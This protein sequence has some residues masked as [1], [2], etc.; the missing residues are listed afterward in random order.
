MTTTDDPAR[1][2][3]PP[4]VL[5]ALLDQ[6]AEGILIVDADGTIVGSNAASASI[7]PE[8]VDATP[9]RYD[10]FADL[11]E[12]RDGA[13]R[14]LPLDAWPLSHALRGEHVA[15]FEMS[16][17]NRRTGETF[18]HE[19]DAGPVLGDDG[20]VLY[21]IS[22]RRDVT[23]TRQERDALERLFAS[24]HAAKLEAERANDL[25]VRINRLAVDLGRV[26]TP[27]AVANA[28]ARIARE[29]AEATGVGIV[30][31]EPDGRTLE[32][33]ATDGFPP[34]VVEPWRTFDVDAP[35]PLA[36]SVRTDEPVFVSSPT[37]RSAR[38]LG[39]AERTPNAISHAWACFPLHQTGLVSGAIGFGFPD[40]RTFPAADTA[41]L[42]A[43]ADQISTAIERATLL[44]DSERARREAEDA[45]R[46]LRR[47]EFVT[48]AAISDLPFEELLN[49]LLD[50]V[51]S[52]LEADSST[53]LLL[54]DE[55]GDLT[56]RAS[57]GLEGEI[58]GATRIPVGE[59]V[60][61]RILASAQPLVVEDLTSVAIVSRWV[62]ETMRSLVGVPLRVRRDLVG[63]LHVAT[64]SPRAFTNDDIRLLELVGARVASALE[65]AALY[66]ER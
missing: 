48:D 43:I 31:L 28:G 65:R 44:E 34:E 8:G 27:S 18:L 22:L 33:V 41:F 30:Q 59:G 46:R 1:R 6:L 40:V 10:A 13:G 15:R 14:P 38:F 20:K 7:L 49:E 29:A 23:R 63:V 3:L 50:R 66:G 55:G 56:V 39:I 26:L 2:Q 53:L 60:A 11:F 45:L 21:A 24:E 54:D 62:P 64:A 51:R 16:V 58:D 36:E 17:R 25:L 4:D 57:R 19:I 47:L 12:V 32:T 9:H 52:A 5:R 61:G 37:E 42:G 35:A